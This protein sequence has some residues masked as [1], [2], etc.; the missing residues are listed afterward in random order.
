MNE[1]SKYF[2]QN[3]VKVVVVFGDVNSTLAGAMAA[4]F[5]NL[6][7]VHIEAGL[8][9]FNR[10][11]PEERNRV[12]VDHLSNLL[13]T[14]EPS[15]I[16][17]L[18]REGIAGK[19]HFLGNTMIDTLVHFLPVFREMKTYDQF[20][21]KKNK[22]VLATVHRQENVESKQ[23]LTKIINGL[24]AVQRMNDV[25]VI[26]PLHPRTR[27]ALLKHRILTGHLHLVPPQGYL[28]M[29]NLVFNCGVLITDSGGLQEESSYLGVPCITIR[30]ET[31]R[32][33]TIRSGTNT[34]LP[35][36]AKEFVT[37]LIKCV[38]V[39]LGVRKK[40]LELLRGLMGDGKTS[41]KVATMLMA[42]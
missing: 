12:L 26:I 29:M 32:P 42:I 16:D 25:S 18:F 39:K 38:C 11:M 27:A 8:R 13:V 37:E 20:N 15:A 34:L 9:S 28:E 19:A 40:R 14:T 17:N 6:F 4:S 31:E 21:L 33:I 7:V 36:T 10:S 22:Y 30:T 3:H 35:P 23:R 5:L 41:N 2:S 24:S 1:L